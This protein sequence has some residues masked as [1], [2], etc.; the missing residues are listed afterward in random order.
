MRLSYAAGL[1]S[2][3]AFTA[4]LLK[5]ADTFMQSLSDRIQRAGEPLTLETPSGRVHYLES[6]S[7]SKDDFVRGLP[8]R[9]RTGP[10]GLIAIL[11]CVE[12]CRRYEIHRNLKAKHLELPSETCMYVHC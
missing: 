1:S 2:F 11:I 9:Q 3:L 8:A 12:P 4:I 6:S 10:D 7:Q 5:N